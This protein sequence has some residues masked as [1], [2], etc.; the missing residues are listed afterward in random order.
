MSDERLRELERAWRSA[1]TIVNEAALI[2]E[3]LR[4]GLLDPARLELVALMGA[5]AAMRVIATKAK[6]QL[7]ED[8]ADWLEAVASRNPSYAPR[9]ACAA[10]RHVFPLWDRRPARCERHG[11]L[12]CAE[13]ACQVDPRP[14][15]MLELVETYIVSSSALVQ[16]AE[17]ERALDECDAAAVDVVQGRGS[18]TRYR[19]E[20]VLLRATYDEGD[21]KVHL[22]LAAGWAVASLIARDGDAGIRTRLFERLQPPDSR[23]LP[24]GT[25]VNTLLGTLPRH[26]SRQDPLDW[27]IAWPALAVQAVRETLPCVRG[28]ARE[29]AVER[30]VDPNYAIGEAA[31]DVRVAM[32]KELALFVLGLGDPLLDRTGTPPGTRP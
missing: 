16:P 23:V 11:A 24:G 7:P 14:R 29:D 28:F 32:Q 22:A 20:D 5:P 27:N 18:G 25:V 2:A 15:R 3:R 30:R 13:S 1:R 10:L 8:P 31:A 17:L 4:L 12:D 9:G 26:V 21:R 6:A 19:G